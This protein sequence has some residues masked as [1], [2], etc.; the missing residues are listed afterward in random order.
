M[1]APA[2]WFWLLGAG[3]MEIGK[4][5]LALD[6]LQMHQSA[7]R[8]VDKHQQ[9]AVRPCY[10][11]GRP[12]TSGLNG[13]HLSGADLRGANLNS[14][15]LSDAN[16]SSANITQLQLDRACGTNV[17]LDP[18]LTIRPSCQPQ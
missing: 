18:G 13:A 2:W 15:N 4:R 17:K 10:K 11:N 16:L 9:G 1:M 6:K 8:I 14:A 5:R 3:R 12:V 7:G